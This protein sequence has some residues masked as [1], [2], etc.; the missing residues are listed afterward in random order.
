M[1]SQQFIERLAVLVVHHD[2]GGIVGLE[3]VA[4][5]HYVRMLEAGQRPSLVQKPAQ[6]PL[7]A[8]AVAGRL[9]MYFGTVAHGDLVRQ[10]LLHGDLNGEPR[11]FAKVGDAETADAKDPRNTV[12]ADTETA[13]QCLLVIV[14]AHE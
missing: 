7:E 1:A 12:G 14:G 9:R 2:V 3:A 5:A 10:V 13:R 6:A 11:V 8:L 4:Y